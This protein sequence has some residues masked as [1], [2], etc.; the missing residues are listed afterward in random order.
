MTD[1]DVR[2][3][4]LLDSRNA[5]RDDKDRFLEIAE[6]V[7]SGAAAEFGRQLDEIGILIVG[8]DQKY[9]RFAAPRQL[10][11][12]GTIPTTKRDSI[13]VSVY[14]KKTGEANNNVPL[15]KRVAF[16]ESVKVGVKAQP[17]MKMVTVPILSEGQVIGV[18]QVS[19]KGATLAAAGS[20]FNAA[21][22]QKIAAYFGAMA[23]YLRDGRPARF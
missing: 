19:K 5:V 6:V 13:A 17:I 20:D 7:A 21:D 12:L 18:A 23:A 2:L 9:L 4:N 1:L 3:S 11:D 16:F 22:V 8:S 14:T 10:C 15:A